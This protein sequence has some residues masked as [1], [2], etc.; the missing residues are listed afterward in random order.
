[1]LQ[2]FTSNSRGW[3]IVALSFVVLALTFSAR[4]TV[5]F[6]VPMWEIDP[7]WSRAEIS[8]GGA[9]MLVTM[10]IASAVTGYLLDRHGPRAIYAV[11]LLALTVTLGGTA[12]VSSYALF[13]VLYCVGGGIAY[14]TATMTVVSATLARYFPTNRGLATG[15]ALSG[16]TSGLLFLMPLFAVVVGAIGWRASFLAMA[17]LA[18]AVL[19]ASWSVLR[20]APQA[21][22]AP[23]RAGADGAARLIDKLGMLVRDRTFLLLL[24]GFSICG[25]TTAGVYEVHMLPYA[26]L[27]GFVPLEGATAYGL[28]GASNMAGL[29]AIGWL[30]D[31]VH[32]PLLLG[33]M[34]LARAVAYVILLNV[35]GDLALFLAFAALFGFLNFATLPVVANI[36]ASHIGVRVMGLTLGILFGGHS[37]GGALGAFYGGVIFDAMARYDWVWLTAIALL[38]VAALATVMIG[39]RPRRATLTPAMA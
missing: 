3:M 13:L 9:V 16:S 32:R 6:L 37:L 23:A 39:E 12:L 36:V 5:G 2:G 18:F 31:R 27:C 4:A 22:A 28:A 25:F 17:G 20:N 8:T 7:G 19:I 1:M 30:A 21:G 29:V 15:F 35:T 34:Y 24:V 10:G 14:G 38:L 33:G 26:A 11:G